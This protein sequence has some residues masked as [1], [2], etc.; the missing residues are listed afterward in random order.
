MLPDKFTIFLKK[1]YK[2]LLFK[3]FHYQ[4]R[5]SYSQCG[6]DA[7]V[8]SLFAMLGIELPTYLDI[9]TNHPY[10]FSNTYFFYEKGSC[11]VCIEP[12]PGLCREIRRSRP[13]D[14][15]INAGISDGQSREADFFILDPHT[16]NTFSSEEVQKYTKNNRHK[17]VK[18]IKVP[19]L[20]INQIFK[21]HCV[22]TPNFVNI[23]VEGWEMKILN[24]LDFSEF[25]PTVFCIE[26]LTYA[27][28]GHEKKITEIIEFMESKNYFKFADTYINSIFVDKNK[29]NN[30]KV[31]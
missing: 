31:C 21:E 2:K 30:R 24:S 10:N 29:W 3:F 8:D 11:G 19:L 22:D 9:G 26:T 12:D 28:P 23:D 18:T 25:R 5:T 7:I 27:A 6:E 14:K 4:Y 15:C 17:L 20:N 16:L 1:L 13:R